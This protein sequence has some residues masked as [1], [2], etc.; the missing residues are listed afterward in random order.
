MSEEGYEDEWNEGDE[1]NESHE[2]SWADDQ[3]WNEG[4]WTYEDLYCTI[5]MSMDI[6]REKEKEKEK[7]KERKERQARVMMAK[8]ENQ[9]MAKVSPVMFNLRPHRQL[10]YRTNSRNKLTILMQ[11]QALVMVSLQWQRQNQ[12]V[13]VLTATYAEREEHRRTHRGGQNQ[14]DAVSQ[15]NRKEVK[16]F[17][18]L[19]GDLDAL[20]SGVHRRPAPFPREVGLIWIL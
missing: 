19:V 16:R 6:S 3:N 12:H 11:H 8:E 14:R 1:W 17:P 2:G 7:E 15:Q 13:D 10:P 4:F 5:L 9:E 18:V 20:R